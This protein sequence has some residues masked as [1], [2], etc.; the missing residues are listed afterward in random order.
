MILF[1][2]H[3][4]SEVGAEMGSSSSIDY[5]LPVALR[6]AS[7]VDNITLGFT[8]SGGSGVLIRVEN[9]GARYQQISLDSGELDLLSSKPRNVKENTEFRAKGTVM[10]MILKSV[11]SQTQN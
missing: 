3:F 6:Q 4:I 1:L 9:D 5:T 7:E 10:F 8:T 2:L 11:I